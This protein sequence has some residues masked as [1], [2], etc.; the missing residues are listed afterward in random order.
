MN[1]KEI[2]AKRVAQEIKDGDVVNLGIG[3]PE[4]VANYIDEDMTVYFQAENGIMGM[5][6]VAEG[7]DIDVNVINAGCKHVLTNKGACYFDSA[8]SF[9][10]IRG[11]HVDITVLGVLQ[12]D[13]TGSFASHKI[14]GK[15]IPGMG[16]AM[17][18]VTGAKQ[19]I[20]AT[21]H[22]K[23]GGTPTIVK[24]ISLPATAVNKVNM[25]VTELAVI[26]VTDAGL[27]LEE[28]AEG[29]TIEEIQELTEPQLI[30]STHLKK[31]FS[32]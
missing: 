30:V 13:E 21:T 12:V 25:I 19:V 2:I 18:L 31:M 6:G 29:H 3:L 20:V 14:P 9:A 1:S 7:D 4:M 28:I 11:G 24:K 8:T 27:V 26:R 17:D 16:G 22:T 32:E 23:K 10:I 5:G 15:R